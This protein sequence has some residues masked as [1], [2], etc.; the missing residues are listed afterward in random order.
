LRRCACGERKQ[1]ESR[2][3]PNSRARALSKRS[4]D[5]AHQSSLREQD[6]FLVLPIGHYASLT[7]SALLEIIIRS[8]DSEYESNY[9]IYSGSMLRRC[10]IK[11]AMR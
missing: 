11:A 4:A 10:M 7:C 3:E 5:N 1:Q 8:I 2:A 6:S 9:E